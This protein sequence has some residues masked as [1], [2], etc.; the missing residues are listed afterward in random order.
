[1]PKNDILIHSP[2]RYSSREGP[3]SQDLPHSIYNIHP[4]NNSISSYRTDSISTPR[5]A[6]DLVALIR[7]TV[8]S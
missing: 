4:L 5:L 6:N 1:M 3:P 2:G 8:L 7:D